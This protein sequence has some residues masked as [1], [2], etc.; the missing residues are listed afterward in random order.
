MI[1]SH[2]ALVA[3]P[4]VA[5]LTAACT[6]SPLAPTG[7]ESPSARSAQVLQAKGGGGG[8][9][10]GGGAL[11]GDL[12]LGDSGCP[13]KPSSSLVSTASGDVT[14]EFHI[15]WRDSG[16][17]IVEP[18]GSSYPLTND[19][20]LQAR[21][22]KN[23]AT[24]DAVTLYGQDIIG[25]DGIQHETDKILI[26]PQQASASGFTLHVHADKVVVYR[27]SGHTGGKRVGAIGTICIGD[28]VYRQP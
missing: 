6:Q 25:P 21:Y 4:F 15:L 8:G 13:A 27:L 28:V 24:I 3:V 20:I 2:T 22:R 10:A 1:R 23:N 7:L 17:L 9:T 11:D 18:E 12:I 26:A 5:V 16:G 14:D 19:V